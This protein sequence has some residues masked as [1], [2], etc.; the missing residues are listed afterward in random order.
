MPP[1]GKRWA[2]R[3]QSRSRLT[4]R[5]KATAAWQ[6]WAAVLSLGHEVDWTSLCSNWLTD[7][8][9]GL[10]NIIVLHSVRLVDRTSGPIR[11]DGLLTE[12]RAIADLTLHQL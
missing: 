1:T 11:M 9:S 10:Y 12:G 8:G 7:T 5:N 4:Q 6:V 2:R 3:S